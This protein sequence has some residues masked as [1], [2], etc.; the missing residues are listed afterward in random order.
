MLTGHFAARNT[1]MEELD[2]HF[3]R[4]R[5]ETSKKVGFVSYLAKM[6]ED[7]SV[8]ETW[9]VAQERHIVAL[10]QCADV[11]TKALKLYQTL[12]A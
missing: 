1:E 2:E 9:K 7:E 12:Q 11:R 5:G 4:N 8:M 6:E 10:Q 3:I